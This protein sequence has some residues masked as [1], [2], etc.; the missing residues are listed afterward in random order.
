MS[1]HSLFSRISGTVTNVSEVTYHS[2]GS[3][4]N[5]Y[6]RMSNGFDGTEN[7]YNPTYDVVHTRPQRTF[8]TKS[9][10]SWYNYVQRKEIAT[11]KKPAVPRSTKQPTFSWNLK[12]CTFS[13][14]KRSVEAHLLLTGCG[15]LLEDS[16]FDEY[17]KQGEQ[18]FSTDEFWMQYRVTYAQATYDIKYLFGLLLS[19]MKEKVQLCPIL[20][21]FY[22]NNVL[23]GL[24]AWR[25]LT[26]HY[27]Y[28][29]YKEAKIHILEERLRKPCEA[30]NGTEVLS[31]LNTYHSALI[32]LSELEDDS[33]FLDR[34]HLIR[35]LMRSLENT[36]AIPAF[37]HYNLY[38]FLR[39][40]ECE[41][42]L[43]YLKL[44]LGSFFYR[45]L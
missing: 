5:R 32:E 24:R 44:K 2:F 42:P 20:H 34:R 17:Q 33:P 13:T 8:D 7:V 9:T 40:H 28:G 14:Y 36:P 6:Y 18:Y 19:T 39:D 43:E 45:S 16:V 12:Y 31:Y 25:E 21:N 22:L 37:L 29:P 23:D 1:T 30:T 35:F 15:Y 3:C 38:E 26:D 11:R 4:T 41:K 10:D 27:I